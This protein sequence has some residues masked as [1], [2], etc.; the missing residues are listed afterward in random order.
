MTT[1]LD[2]A[3][4]ARAVVVVGVVCAAACV[5]DVVQ[6][7]SGGTGGTGTTS[8]SGASTTS[9]SGA[10]ASSSS[11]ASTTS[12]SEGSASSSGSGGG[13]TDAGAEDGPND[14]ACDG[15]ILDI[16]GFT[17]SNIGASLG[18]LGLCGLDL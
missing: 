10:S 16:L 9:S 18:G 6:T 2:R 4:W 3:W 7:P 11:G 1:M 14:A 12:S 17:P 15:S 13:V 8:S 5:P